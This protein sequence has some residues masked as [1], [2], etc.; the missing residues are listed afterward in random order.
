MAEVHAVLFAW[1]CCDAGRGKVS[2]RQEAAA[3]MRETGL[4]VANHM[5][6]MRGHTVLEEGVA[7]G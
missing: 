6:E 5:G 7:M 1:V 2:V 3:N 4:S